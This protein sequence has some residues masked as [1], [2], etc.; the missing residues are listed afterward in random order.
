MLRQPRRAQ[1]QRLAGIPASP[2][3]PPTAGRDVNRTFGLRKRRGVVLTPPSPRPQDQEPTA[4]V[5]RPAFHLLGNVSVRLS[6]GDQLA[7][8]PKHRQLLA[9]LLLQANSPVPTEALIERLWDGTPPASAFGNLKTYIWELRRSISPHDPSA[10]PIDT[11]SNG[12]RVTA[13]AGN[14]DVIRFRQLAR[15]GHQALGHND[16]ITAWDRF[17][18][19]LRTW[20]GRA[21]QDSR[22]LRALRDESDRLEEQ[23]VSV[24][25]ELVDLLIARGAYADSIDRL[26][27][28]MNPGKPRERLWG[29]LMLAL[30]LDGRQIEALGT[31]QQLRR[32]LIDSAGVDP[33]HSVQ[34][35]HERM[36][37]ADVTLGVSWRGS[38]GATIF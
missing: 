30:Y 14:L 27:S 18:Q 8:R 13:D 32:L 20:N 28:V 11:V 29:Q 4:Y 10:A 12:Y 31:Y 37:S 35:L 23:R 34:R 2:T 17:D 19:A 5:R 1:S 6:T 38:A 24:V 3:S 22:T 9:L 16:H 7:L 36:L 26:H 33:T 15:E 21:L 25:T